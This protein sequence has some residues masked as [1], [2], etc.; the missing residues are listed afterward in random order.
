[1]ACGQSRP[2]QPW[3]VEGHGRHRALPHRSAS[4]RRCVN[5]LLARLWRDGHVARCEGCAHTV[6]AFNS[7]RDRHCP[8]CQAG[9]ARKWLAEREA[10]LV[11]TSYFHL[12]FTLPAAVADIAWQNKAVV[13]DLLFKASAEATITIAADPRHLGAKVGMT[14]VLHT[15]A[16]RRSGCRFAARKARYLTWIAR[17][18][19]LSGFGDD[20][21]PACAYDRDRWRP[22]RRR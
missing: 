15:R 12:V 10:E 7:C 17:R 2:C 20:P 18:G 6:V 16:C 19:A 22:V 11:D 3:P 14:A 21:P 1:M 5:R 4:H 13:Y 8:K 9:A